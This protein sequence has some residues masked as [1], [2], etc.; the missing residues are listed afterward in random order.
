[1]KNMGV[2]FEIPNKYGK[3]L[4]D[5]LEPLPFSEYH[6]LIDN[7]EIHL[8]ENN[9]FTNEFLFKEEHR[10]ISGEGLYNTAK[11]NNYY[12]VFVTLKAFYKN[13]IVQPV[14][15]YRE[16]LD[17]DCQV[18]LA[19][20]DCSYVM[21]WCKNNKLVLNMYNYAQSKGYKNIKYISEK[22][23]IEKKYIID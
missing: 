1:M 5:I 4:S 15:S 18:A 6:W 9:E 19:V 16:F 22:D 12:L 13:G 14:S 10:I 3:Y 11:T 7:D 8:L 23:L 20:Y 21:F 2:V 17:S